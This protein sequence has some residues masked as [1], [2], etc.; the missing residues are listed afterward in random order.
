MYLGMVLVLLGC[1]MLVGTVW[2]LPVIPLF[3]WLITSRLDA[4][5]SAMLCYQDLL[6]QPG[7]CGREVTVESK[8]IGPVGIEDRVN[9]VAASGRATHDAVARISTV[10]E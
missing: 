3:I 6:K 9:Q 10:D 7:S 4:L 5:S 1:A 8:G 2:P